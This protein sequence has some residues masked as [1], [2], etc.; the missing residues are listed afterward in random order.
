M[1]MAA[2]LRTVSKK[3]VTLVAWL[4]CGAVLAVLPDSARA[5]SAESLAVS[6]ATAV[7]AGHYYMY[8]DQPIPLR[9]VIDQ[10][11]VFTQ[12]AATLAALADYGMAVADA[13]PHVVPGWYALAVP[14]E[15]QSAPAVEALC[16]LLAT[17]DA[18]H[19]ISPMLLDERGDPLY[20]TQDL[21]VQFASHV[22]PE[23][24]LR[25]LAAAGV[26]E[27]LDQDWADLPNAY[28]ARFATR[29]GF[30]VLDAANRLAA[31]DDVIFAEPDMLRVNRRELIPNDIFFSQL[32]GIRN[33]G[34]SGGTAGMDMKG[35]LAWDLTL[36]SPDITVVILDDG[37]QSSHPDLNV[38]AQADFTTAGTGGEPGNSCDNHGTAVAS[39][40]G[41]TINNFIG[42]AGLAPNCGLAAAKWT[43]SNVPCNGTGFH[44]TTWLVNALIWSQSIGARVTN[45]SNSFSPSSSITS[46]YSASRIAGMVH[47]AST[48]NG[49][50]STIGYPAS[51]STVNGVGAVN[52][53]GNR[54]SF[55]QYGT[56][57]AFVAPGQDIRVT[58]RT[59]SAGYEATD[60][61][62]A[63]G[64]SFASPYAAAAAA[65]VLSVDPTLNAVQVEQILQSTCT[66][67]GPAGY[68][69][70]FGYGIVNAYE[71]VLAALPVTAPGDFNLLVPAPGATE[72]G[73]D[74]VT[75][76][77]SAASGADSY[78]FWIA[79][80]PDFANPV[81][82]R[83]AL[84]TLQTTVSGLDQNTQYYWR[85]IAVNGAGAQDSTPVLAGFTT[86]LDCNGNGVADSLD[87]ASGWSIDCNG[88]GIPDECDISSESHLDCNG[89]GVLDSCELVLGGLAGSYFE[90]SALSGPPR[91][92]IESLLNFNWGSNGPWPGWADGFSARWTG[93]LETSAG[94][95]YELHVLADHGVRL[96]LAGELLVDA[97]LDQP[98]TMHTAAVALG[99]AQTYALQVEYYHGSGSATLQ[100]LWTP[101]GGSMGLIPTANLWAGRDCNASG[102]LDACDLLAGTS[103]DANGDGIPDECQPV[104]P[105]YC[106]GDMNCDGIVSFADISLFIA[107]IKV[108]GPADWEYDPENGVCAYLNGDFSGN[109]QVDFGDISGFIGAIKAGSPEPCTTVP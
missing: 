95:A 7:Q 26:A 55:S 82:V 84:I 106:L 30:A 54:A 80:T 36:G 58:D 70:E 86:F 41:A 8:F 68:D 81:V 2:M 98:L 69:T 38:T 94:G 5:G 22:S 85:V 78:N 18:A 3:R 91:G 44:N 67:R 4:V 105:Q 43:I 75:F 59:G 45:N 90:N 20:V 28:R 34:Q 51:L 72:V 102:T 71:A 23:D 21:L 29:D 10:L 48:G 83:E 99:A 74:N 108:A 92:R 46:R 32:W 25:A 93:Y 50:T 88:N 31:S 76:E 97:W 1:R 77:W 24:A 73:L 109:G 19:T 65:L 42:V 104:I 101:P 63:S 35:H 53:N 89:N 87:L 33:T 39:C 14:A 66:D 37:I 13:T 16:A 9:L 57:I 47:F 40:V 60:Y 12:D 96:W 64:T 27:V 107:A 56:G 61:A 6:K 103:L 11:A 15:A 100:L 17:I 49:G 62:W 52:R 79:Q